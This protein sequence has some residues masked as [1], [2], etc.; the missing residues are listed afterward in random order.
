M[1]DEVT[2]SDKNNKDKNT[3]E[4]IFYHCSSILASPRHIMPKSCDALKCF[5]IH[6][7]WNL[8]LCPTG[9]CWQQQNSLGMRAMVA[10]IRCRLASNIFL[11][12]LWCHCSL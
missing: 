1:C 3:M 4:K 12:P 5:Y 7:G 2:E 10:D 6:N 9:R 8:F 11:L